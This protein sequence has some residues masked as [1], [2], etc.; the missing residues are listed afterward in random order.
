MKIY[1]I[2]NTL[3]IIWTLKTEMSGSVHPLPFFP[4]YHYNNRNTQHKRHGTGDDKQDENQRNFLKHTQNPQNPPQFISS[5]WNQEI[6]LPQKVTPKP[7]ISR[8]KLHK[9]ESWKEWNYKMAEIYM[10][11]KVQV[12]L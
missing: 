11:N 2:F 6:P 4:H 8:Q 10:R 3:N 1:Y 7:A 9:N 5:F 12:S